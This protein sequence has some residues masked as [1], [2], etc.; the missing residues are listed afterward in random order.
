[1]SESFDEN[2]PFIS[3]E[4]YSLIPIDKGVVGRSGLLI[5]RTASSGWSSAS[6]EPASA[7]TAP[8]SP[9]SFRCLEESFTEFRIE[10]MKSDKSG[11]TGSE[12]K[13]HY[14]KNWPDRK[15]GN[16]EEKE[17]K[18]KK[19]KIEGEYETKK[20]RHDGNY[21]DALLIVLRLEFFS[22]VRSNRL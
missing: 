18:E 2:R 14:R 6:G 7:A 9:I 20:Q 5:S 17:S 10:V 13:Q 11:D 1:M 15:W 3:F 16:S 21:P 12:C 8:K 4:P 19:N 22:F